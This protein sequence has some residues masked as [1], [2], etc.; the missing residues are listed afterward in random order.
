M[1]NYKLNTQSLKITVIILKLQVANIFG[2]YM[3]SWCSKSSKFFNHAVAVSAVCLKAYPTATEIV[4]D[5]TWVS[6]VE[7]VYSFPKWHLFPPAYNSWLIIMIL[8]FLGCVPTCILCSLTTILL[9]TTNLPVI[10]Q[11]KKIKP[12]KLS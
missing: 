8:I 1:C 4:P 2:F 11:A 9:K 12:S 3:Y 6:E 5:I 7:R 10:Y